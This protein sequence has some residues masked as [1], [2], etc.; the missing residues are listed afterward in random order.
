MFSLV[1]IADFSG[2]SYKLTRFLKPQTQIN[3]IFIDFEESISLINQNLYSPDFIIINISN[4]DQRINDLRFLKTVYPNACPIVI[5]NDYHKN[6]IGKLIENGIKGVFHENDPVFFK[7]EFFNLLSHVKNNGSYVSQQFTY[8]MF[9]HIESKT[10]VN[11][12]IRLTDRQNQIINFLISGDTYNDI[13]HKMD[14][15]VNT[16]RKHIA[17]L[18]KKL[19][20]KNRSSLFKIKMHNLIEFN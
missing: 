7:D 6:L 8:Q 14:V 18:Y 20:V 10:T 19:N 4:I 2:F 12:K 17:I 15:S 1:F 5:T 16:T 11:E 3:K 13:A 9:E